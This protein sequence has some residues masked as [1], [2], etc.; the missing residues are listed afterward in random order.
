MR[1]DGDG[2]TTSVTPGTA[3]SPCKPQETSWNHNPNHAQERK[4]N[5]SRGVTLKH[6]KV[7]HKSRDVRE[8]VRSLIYLTVPN[9]LHPKVKQE[10]QPV[11]WLLQT[12]A[13]LAELEMVAGGR[14]REAALPA[15]TGERVREWV[16]EE[17]EKT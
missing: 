12:Y 10:L 1:P 5:A 14:S 17:K 11:I 6:S 15:D 16:G 7:G 3:G 13:R 8:T 2:T 4:R 9:E